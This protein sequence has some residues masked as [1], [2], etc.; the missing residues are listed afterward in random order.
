MRM[1]ACYDQIVSSSPFQRNLE[2]GKG[3]KSQE[4]KGTIT[5]SGGGGRHS[6]A[7]HILHILYTC[8]MIV[9]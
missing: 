3:K 5:V 7:C 8:H 9:T 1:L 6:I 4:T 2:G